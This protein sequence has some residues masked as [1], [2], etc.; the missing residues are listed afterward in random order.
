M[1]NKFYFIGDPHTNRDSTLRAMTRTTI[2]TLNFAAALFATIT[3]L[4]ILF[5]SHNGCLY[6]QALT[7]YTGPCRILSINPSS[8]ELPHLTLIPRS[9]AIPEARKDALSLPTSTP[10]HKPSTLNR[11]LVRLLYL[12]HL[13]LQLSNLLQ[14][15]CGLSG[16]GISHQL[17][18]FGIWGG[19]FVR[20]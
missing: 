12:P 6:T 1:S 16:F 10:G 5:A 20:P 9:Y 8:G 7:A 2:L 11:L 18:G 4:P 15:S 17:L 13:L 14:A 19:H 3:F